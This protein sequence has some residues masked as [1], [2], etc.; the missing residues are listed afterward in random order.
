MLLAFME[1]R[2]VFAHTQD[3]G[4]LSVCVSVS[5]FSGLIAMECDLDKFNGKGFAGKIRRRSQN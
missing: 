5:V 4:W 1:L 2:K 3:V